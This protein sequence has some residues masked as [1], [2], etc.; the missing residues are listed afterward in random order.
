MAVINS[1]AVF[2][3]TTTTKTACAL[4]VHRFFSACLTCVVVRCGKKQQNL[5]IQTSE[6]QTVMN[7]LERSY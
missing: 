1:I 3:T 5:C 2:A 6:K 7:E 4:F